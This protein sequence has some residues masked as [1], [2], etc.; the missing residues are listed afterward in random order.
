MKLMRRLSFTDKNI[1]TSSVAEDNYHFHE[2]DYSNECPNCLKSFNN[3]LEY[4]VH[5]HVCNFMD[6]HIKQTK[7][8]NNLEERINKLEKKQKTLILKNQSKNSKHI[9][10]YKNGY[11]NVEE[12]CKAG[13]KTFEQWKKCIKSQKIIAL[14]ETS[15]SCPIIYVDKKGIIWCSVNIC[16]NIS[17]WLG[18]EIELAFIE[19]MAEKKSLKRRKTIKKYTKGNCIYII[20][21][22]NNKETYKIGISDNFPLFLATLNTSS[23][24]DYI[25]HY[26]KYIKEHRL[27]M[28]IL[29][30]KLS[31]YKVI[32]DSDWFNIK[33]ISS[34]KRY[35]DEIKNYLSN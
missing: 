11:I 21:L 3:D 8:I 14:L 35:I 24:E 20:S 18:Y 33:N 15:E 7:V 30:V 6:I 31:N 4:T 25:I 10:I 9:I 26:V 1:M 23:K 28:D 34:V 19:W 12:L 27:A 5:M 22:P 29:N 13:N 32:E 16:Y 17:S 2:S